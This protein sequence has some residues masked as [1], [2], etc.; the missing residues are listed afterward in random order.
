MRLKPIREEI[1]AIDRQLVELFQKR[2]DCSRKVAQ[3]KIENGMS[4]F[5]A[6]REQQILDSVEEKAGNYGGSARLLYASIM[7]LSRALQHDILGSGS[8]LKNRIRNAADSIPYPDADVRVACFGA[9]GAYAHKAAQKV[10]PN[11]QPVFFSPFK[12]VFEAIRNGQADFGIVP[13]ENSSAGSVTAVY[14]LLLQYRFSIAAAAD[15]R[16]DHCLAVR[17]GCGFSDI[18]K[19]FSHEQALSQCSDFLNANRQIEVCPYV[20][21]AQAARLVAE[22]E[23]TGLAAICSADAAEEY[24]LEILRRGFQNNPNNTTRFIVIARE[25]YIEPQ[26]D[27]ISLS[28]ALPH[29]T[30]SLYSTLCRF[31]AHGLNLTKIESRPRYGKSFEYT[32]YLDFAGTT[33]D[34]DVL[35]LLGALSE[36]LVDFSFLGNYREF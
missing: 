16:V 13:I 7:E 18:R 2:M 11:C 17:R 5:N 8:N 22:S 34:A 20:S 26:A 24:G 14:D 27:K 19:V 15:I 25:M 35:G 23:E 9:A 6:E 36:E 31:A 12:E 3:Y 10:F 29:V 28:F 1:D 32:F 4:V 33:S 21:T 30:G